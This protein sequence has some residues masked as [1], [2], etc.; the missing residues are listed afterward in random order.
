[1]SADG[2]C[3]S[4]PAPSVVAEF[5]GDCVQDG[6]DDLTLRQGGACERTDPWEAPIQGLVLDVDDTLLDTRSAMSSA[7]VAAASTALPGHGTHV[8]EALSRGFYDDP[9]GHFDA[10][11][12]GEVPFE[13][14]RRLRYDAALA[15]LD[16][17]SDDD[18]FAAYERAYRAAFAGVQVLFGDVA[19]LLDT[20]EETGVSV[21]LLTNSGDDQTRLKLAAVGWT[22]RFPVVTTDTIGVGKPDPRLF[23][24]ACDLID[25][26]AHATVCVGDTLAADVLGARA[27][28]MRAAWLCRPDRPAPRNSGWGTPVDDPAVRIVPD[29]ITVASWLERPTPWRG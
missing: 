27:A 20:A 24:A 1:M 22:D 6:Q 5:A 8:H 29:L 26:E 15:A 25:V 11:T 19:V 4:A 2:R 12:R 28:G 7:G 9:G 23:A 10:Y 16:I 17:P 14:Q 18:Q 13:R 21:C 3:G